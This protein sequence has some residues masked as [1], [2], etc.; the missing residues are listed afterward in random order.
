MKQGIDQG[1]LFRRIKMPTVDLPWWGKVLAAFKRPRIRMAE[2]YEVQLPTGGVVVIPNGFDNDGGSIPLFL[3]WALSYVG[4]LLG[5]VYLHIGMFLMLIGLI[6]NPFGLMLIAFMVHDFAVRFGCLML[7]TGE[8]I[9]VPS[10]WAANRYMRRV[11]FMVNDMILLGLTA[12]AGVTAGAWMA[13]RRHRRNDG[14]P[15]NDIAQFQ[16]AN[17]N[18]R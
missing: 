3:L 4:A 11:N 7:K 16:E 14:A 8:I 10:V 12:H 6:L 2:D 1:P 9:P 15:V 5:D 17:T 18:G 13:W